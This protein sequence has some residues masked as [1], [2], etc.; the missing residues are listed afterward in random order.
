MNIIFINRKISIIVN[1]PVLNIYSLPYIYL[2][3]FYKLEKIS[4]KFNFPQSSLKANFIY[5]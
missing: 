3:K 1:S 5:I 4:F 2:N